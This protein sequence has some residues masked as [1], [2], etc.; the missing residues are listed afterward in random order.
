VAEALDLLVDAGFADRE[1]DEHWVLRAEGSEAGIR[2]RLARS[3][4]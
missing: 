3:G 1:D 4:F 2:L